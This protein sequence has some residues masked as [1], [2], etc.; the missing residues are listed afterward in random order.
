MNKLSQA[1]S[2]TSP[3]LALVALVGTGGPATAQERRQLDECAAIEAEA[4]RL[5][6][7]DSLLRQAPAPETPIADAPQAPARAAAPAG[8]AAT[9]SQPP[10]ADTAAASPDDAAGPQ[11]ESRRR[12]ERSAES[13]VVVSVRENISGMI[14]FTS[15]DGVIYEQTSAGPVR[16]SDPPFNANLEPASFGSFF[17]IPENEQNRIRVSRRN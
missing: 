17:L 8:A 1:V 12:S 3:V 9:A 16:L 6:C 15:E 5:A 4:E 11:R 2:V 14:V 13:I 10:T 7:Y